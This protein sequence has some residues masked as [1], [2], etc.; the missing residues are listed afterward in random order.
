M[1]MDMRQTKTTSGSTLDTKNRIFQNP[2]TSS[3]LKKLPPPPR[4]SSFGTLGFK[5][6][7]Q[8]TPSNINT[9]VEQAPP[10]PPNDPLFS[11]LNEIVDSPSSYHD[12]QADISISATDVQHAH[13]PA[14]VLNNILL[15][16][17][18]SDIDHPVLVYHLH[19]IQLQLLVQRI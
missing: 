10:K 13:P 14:Y 12:M 9:L 11:D 8:P 3:D 17:S 18:S 19:Q 6:K 15:S 16:S 5:K 1:P 2:T 4:R 7:L